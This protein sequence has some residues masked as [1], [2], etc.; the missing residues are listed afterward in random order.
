MMSGARRAC[1]TAVLAVLAACLWAGAALAQ[2]AGRVDWSGAYAGLSLSGITSDGNADRTRATGFIVQTDV[3]NGLF[4]DAIG[5]RESSGFAGGRLGYNTQQGSVVTGVELA[6]SALD[7]DNDA[8]FSRVDPEI[9]VG[10]DTITRYATRMDGLATLSLR[11][12]YA[13][14]EMLVF[15]RVGFARAEVENR[16]TLDLTAANIPL[17]AF[18]EDSVRWGYSVGL[19]VERR[20]SERISVVG[21]LSY[22]DLEDATVRARAPDIFPGNALD[23]TFR[24][25][26][27]VAS[28]GVN[29]SF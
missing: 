18:D 8:R 24:N 19:G 12:G 27:V 9:L 13:V 11:G 10:V 5:A 29:F 23:Y 3:R 26:G 21:E 15:G 6:I 2:E 25:D 28:I 16:F 22:F 7:Q 14:D 20:V 4:P 1:R 17:L